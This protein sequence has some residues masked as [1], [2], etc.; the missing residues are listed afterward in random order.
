MT[1][2]VSASDAINAQ[3]AVRKG[4]VRRCVQAVAAGESQTL[5]I[6]LDEDLLRDIGR[7]RRILQTAR[8]QGIKR[9]MILRNQLGERLL[10]TSL[11]FSH[12]DCLCALYV[13]RACQISHCVARL[14]IG[15]P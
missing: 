7:V 13:N 11:E 8:D 6:N 3:I 14:H 4:E 9:L 15:C 12:E 1:R 10:G 5:A 2:R